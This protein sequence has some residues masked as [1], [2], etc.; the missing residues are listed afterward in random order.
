M[1]ATAGIITALRDLAVSNRR[2]E[3]RYMNNLSILLR[4]MP[5]QVRL[6]LS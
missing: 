3:A 6:V 5:P 4:E 1:Q 2:P